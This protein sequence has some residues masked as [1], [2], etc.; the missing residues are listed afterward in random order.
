MVQI[1]LPSSRDDRFDLTTPQ[2]RI[3]V[4][5]FLIGGVA[6]ALCML[7][8]GFGPGSISSA[9]C[10]DLHDATA[11]LGVHSSHQ[12]TSIDTPPA[13][14]VAAS[15]TTPR[16]TEIAGKSFLELAEKYGTDK[17]KGTLTLPKCRQ[18]P[19]NC[20]RPDA[21]NEG[22]KVTGHFYNNIYDKWLTP[23]ADQ[24][25]QFV[26]I[27]YFQ[28]TGFDAY[29][30]LLPLA[31]KHSL[32]IACL[33][34]GPRSEGKWPHGNFPSKNPRYQSLLDAKR[35]HCGDASDY[36]FLE[37]VWT[38]HLHRPNTNA[39]PLRVVVEDASHLST[40]MAV[41]VFFWFPLLEPG[42]LLFIE[43]IESQ[44][45]ANKFRTQLMPQLFMDLHYCGL[46]DN[47]VDQG[48][49]L[50]FPTLQP[51]LKGI[52]CELHHCVLE[53]NDRPALDKPDRTLSMP[54]PHALDLT[55][56]LQKS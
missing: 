12:D 49:K 17:V 25:F 9:A 47:E 44:T 42:G 41:S 56:C 34:A 38:E 50:C 43:D 28:G 2:V 6:A 33:P 5:S 52:S 4:P 45:V 39:P 10:E 22:C 27:G 15:V 16:K 26:E 23:L 20:P 21:V 14:A 18:D 31:E 19:K 36:D 55:Q 48:N 11:L 29:T 1:S 37:R 30:D 53:R 51:Y 54:P 32:E 24:V 13:V 8:L 3:N 46:P 7:L 40:H 35:L